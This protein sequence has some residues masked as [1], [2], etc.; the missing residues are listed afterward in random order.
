MDSW[1]SQD[2]CAGGTD[3]RAFRPRR[4]RRADVGRES[5]AAPRVNA[6]AQSVPFRVFQVFG[7]QVITSQLLALLAFFA[8]ELFYRNAGSARQTK[9]VSEAVNAP[10][11]HPLMDRRV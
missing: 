1:G 8:N 4:Q 6:Q 11:L 10:P 7:S 2:A 3:T 5:R 9:R